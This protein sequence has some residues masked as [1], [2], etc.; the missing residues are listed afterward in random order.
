LA[1]IFISYA[2]ED[3]LRAQAL[4]SLLGSQ[5]WTVWWDRR[6]PPGRTYAQV[7]ERELTAARCV[8]V[9]W[10][11][12]SI[13]SDWVQNEAAAGAE[14][15][16]LIPILIEDV[17]PPFEFRRLQ[18]LSLIGWMPGKSRPEL[19]ELIA[20]V[21]E[22]LGTPARES[23]QTPRKAS[24]P[25]RPEKGRTFEKMKGGVKKRRRW[26]KAQVAAVG[27]VIAVA[28]G[29]LLVLALWSAQ[30][31]S[32]AVD[33]SRAQREGTPLQIFLQGMIALVP[34]G[35][36]QNGSDMMALLVDARK[37]NAGI[38]RKCFSPYSPS[39]VFLTSAG[40]CLSAGCTQK[41]GQCICE[42]SRQE[43]SI[44]SNARRPMAVLPRAPA[45]PLPLSPKEAGD[46]SYIANLARPPL[47]GLLNTSF[48]GLVPPNSL[49]ARM[50]FPFE[51]V[52]A[53]RLSMNH[54]GEGPPS[55][56]VGKIYPLGFWK[57]NQPPN[58]EPG[59]ALAQAAVFALT[60][61]KGREVRLNLKSFEST[62]VHS[63]KLRP[64]RDG[65]KVWLTYDSSPY[66]SRDDECT[67]DVDRDF[68]Y[69]YELTRDP[70]PWGERPVPHALYGLSQRL[71]GLPAPGCPVEFYVAERGPISA[72]ASFN[73]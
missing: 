4:A 41:G 49:L 11:A 62:V 44:I 30:D 25:P 15:R 64:G 52:T 72:M 36:G 68:A 18:A 71:K 28:I 69:F 54:E 16:I 27:L 26:G 39:L 55:D 40:E 24:P 43:I 5:G 3:Q 33:A 37:D 59:Q 9:L 56:K 10:S 8:V 7:I 2:R 23:A 1:D 17:R 19:A 60:I 12:L 73:P 20:A 35:A 53:C 14:R 61:P 57:L 32:L 70:L 50:K 58:A 66:A 6:I 63:L 38:P 22:L 67:S 46:F 34:P 51:S 48:L 13:E 21:A 65:Y 47:S 29:I 31:R 42:P 45:H